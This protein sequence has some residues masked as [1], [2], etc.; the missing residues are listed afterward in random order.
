MAKE[1]TNGLG[2]M[3]G[4]LVSLAAIGSAAYF[5]FVRPWHLRWGASEAELACTFP[6]DELVPYPQLN[7]THA[8]SIQASAAEVWPWLVQMGQG[9]GGMYSYELIENAMGLDM[10]NRNSILPEFQNLKVGD[11][12]PL[13]PGGT[14]PKVEILEPGRVLVLHGDSRKEPLGKSAFSSPDGYI[15]MTWGLYLD[16]RCNGLTRLIERV[17]SD[18][19]PHLLR[20]L[21][22]YLLW[23]PGA[24]VMERKML[25]GIKERAEALARSSR[26]TR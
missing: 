6:G 11:T 7:V 14:G 25:L 3:L 19:S 10:H 16:E 4:N 8:V 1:K 15:N 18:W 5:L 13:E 17:R 20:G 26:A 9:R 12:I 22:T 2:R 23:E 24:F 21:D